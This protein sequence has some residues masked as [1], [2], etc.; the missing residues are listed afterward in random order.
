MTRTTPPTLRTTLSSS[1]PWL[2]ALGFGALAHASYWLGSEHE[3]HVVTVPVPPP[4]VHVEPP[5][6]VQCPP[7][8]AQTQAAGPGPMGRLVPKVDALGWAA[9]V[10]ATAAVQCDGGGVCTIDRTFVRGMMAASTSWPS[11][12]RV[13]PSVE[14]GEIVGLK[15]YGV[16]EN[17]LPHA[18]GLENGDLVLAIDQTPLR[19]MGDLMEVYQRLNDRDEF[20]LEIVR[21][22]RSIEK[23]YRLR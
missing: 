4:V 9:A 2:L 10:D 11:R 17:S 19:H 1:V 13:V 20:S 5:R 22:G 6:P 3:V 14:N 12:A 23:H 15:L 18:M 21:Q 7:A 16:R 8:E